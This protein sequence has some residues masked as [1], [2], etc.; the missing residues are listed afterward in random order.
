[1]DSLASKPAGS[2]SCRKTVGLP[3][4]TDQPIAPEKLL[5]RRE[6]TITALRVPVL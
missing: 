6:K 5:S 3:T 4:N 1:M 2:A